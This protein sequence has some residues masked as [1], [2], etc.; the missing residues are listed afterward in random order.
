MK[1]LQ[2]IKNLIRLSEIEVSS[3]KKEQITNIILEKP[4]LAQIIKKKTA[5]EKFLEN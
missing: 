2:R 3:E 5:S 1:I 4:H